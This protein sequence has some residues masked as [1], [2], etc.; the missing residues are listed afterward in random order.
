M[1]TYTALT[2]DQVFAIER[3]AMTNAQEEFVLDRFTDKK[4]MPQKSG[5][6]LKFHYYDHI[7][8]ADVHVL[9]EGVTPAATDLVRVGVSGSLKHQGAWIPFTDLLMAQHENAGEMHKEMGIELG[10][11]LGRV[12]EKDAFTIAL[13]GAGTTVAFTTI[14]AGLKTV[15]TALR[16]ANAPKFTS[17]KSGSTK[18]GTTPVNAGWYLFASIADADLYRGATDFIPVEDYGYTNDIAP[19][20]IGVIKSLGLRIIETDYLADG[21]ALALGDGGLG[22]LSLSS[23][24]RVEYIVQELGSEG[25]TDALKQRGSSGVKSTVGSVVLRSDYV[26]SM[27]TA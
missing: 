6:A 27:A 12:L 13:A 10:Y 3:K 24:N 17:I 2:K 22:S 16:A 15:R 23:K 11:A 19:N 14:D 26:V 9:S 25:S 5:D 4:T 18:V 8:E 21:A 1:A 7:D 20:E